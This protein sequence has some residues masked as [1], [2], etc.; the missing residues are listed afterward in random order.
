[1]METLTF[2]RDEFE[3]LKA[4]QIQRRW[5]WPATFSTNCHG[6]IWPFSSYGYTQSEDREQ[7]RG[8][9]SVIDQ[10]A[11]I[12]LG[13]RSEGGRFFINDKCALYRDEGVGGLRVIAAFQII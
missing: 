11:D 13:I 1:M 7:I 8:L 3:R 5:D 2:T 4:L 6:E 9:S 12:Y 10:A